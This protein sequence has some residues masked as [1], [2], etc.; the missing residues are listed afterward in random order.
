MELKTKYQ[1]TYFIYPFVIKESKYTKYLLKLLKDENCKLRIFRKDK[2]LD[3]YSYFSH[4]ARNYMFSSFNLSK[5]KLAKLEE[6]PLDTKAAILAKNPCTIFEYTIKK[7]IQGKTAE[8]NGI[9]FKIPKIEI[10]CFNTGI[11]FLC[12]KTNIEES[13]KFSDLLNFNYKFRD[14][15]QEFANLNNYDNIRVQTDYFDDVKSFKEFIEDLTGPTAESIKLEIDTERFFTYSYVCID[16]ENWNN[17]N[18]FDKIRNS[19]I[20]YLN[21]L[22][23]DNSVNFS[24]DEMKVISKWNYAKLGMTK[25]GVTLFSSSCDMN[26]FTV[27][28]QEFQQQYLYTY[29]L[30]LYT[31]IY[32]KKI[33]LEFKQGIQLKKTRKEFIK[34]T[35]TL[36]INEVTLQDTGS[37]FNQYLKDVLELKNMYFDTKNKYD[38]LYKEMNI[39]KSAKNNA[40]IV[41]L[42]LAAVAMNIINILFFR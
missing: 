25:Q 34:F 40:F 22:P 15:N 2:D 24:K 36:W 10:I 41:L 8:R 30:A 6:L 1:Y 3:L 12:I 4:R 17:T 39:E 13:D 38:I 7:D 28:P 23:S 19:Y 9:F 16:Q 35:E 14:I 37:L 31:K 20:K 11:C 18:E 27:F 29:I 33:N 5:T 26:N 42:L 21:I 32:L